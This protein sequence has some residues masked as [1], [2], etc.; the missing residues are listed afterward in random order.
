MREVLQATLGHSKQNCV[1]HQ[2]STPPVIAFTQRV[3]LTQDG[4]QRGL[5]V[6]VLQEDDVVLQ[7]NSPRIASSVAC[8]YLYCR[9]M[10]LLCRAL[11]MMVRFF[12]RLDTIISRGGCS[13]VSPPDLQNIPGTLQRSLASQDRASLVSSSPSCLSS[14]P[15]KIS[16]TH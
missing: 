9:R 7:G 1:F 15:K 5:L 13:G 6:L 8:S 4:L 11:W 3:K 12:T 2:E 16:Y 10:T 14:S